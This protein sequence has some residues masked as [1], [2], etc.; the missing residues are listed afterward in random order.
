MQAWSVHSGHQ[1]SAGVDVDCFPNNLSLVG[2]GLI[3]QSDVDG[4]CS[5]NNRGL[6]HKPELVW[7]KQSP[8]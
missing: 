7:V 2:V 8:L 4:D 6:V 3:G 1:T 5:C